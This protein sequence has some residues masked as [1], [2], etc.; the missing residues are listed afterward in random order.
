LTYVITIQSTKV[1]DGQTDRR[2][3]VMHRTVKRP[4]LR[5]YTVCNAWVRNKLWDKMAEC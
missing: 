4:S 2:T 5:G 1:T 3:D